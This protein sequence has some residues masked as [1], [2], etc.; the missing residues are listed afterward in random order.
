M[1]LLNSLK[2][3]K[4]SLIA[5]VAASLITTLVVVGAAGAVVAYKRA[6][7]LNFLANGSRGVGTQE[8]Q[9]E[10]DDAKKVVNDLLNKIS[11]G[12][13]PAAELSMVD[14]VKKSK[15]AVVSIV[16]S[17]DVPVYEQYYEKQSNPFKDIFGQDVPFDFNVP[18]LRQKGT[19][20]KDIG[21]GTGF[22]ISSD[23]LIVTNRHVVADTAASY[24]VITNDGKKYPAEVIA[25]DSVLDVAVV[26]IK[27]A[28]Y[29]YLE[30]GNSDKLEVGQTVLA[31]GNALGEF[32][33][34]VSVGIVSGLARSVVAGGNNGSLE[35]LDQVIQTDA[36]INPGNSGGPLLDTYGRVVGMNAAVAGGG[37]SIG[38]ALPANSIKNVVESVKKTGKIVRPFLG[39]RYVPITKELKD[40]NKLSVDYG[41]LVVRGDKPEE[42]AVVPASPA[43]KA[44]VV[45]ND[46]ILE[47]DGKKLDENTQLALVVRNKKVGD[48]VKLKM[49]HKG[50]TKEIEVKLEALPE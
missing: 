35:R 37:Q 25:R 11:D 30:F 41:V 10:K 28:N 4:S 3:Y 44:G 6:Q 2:Q 42:L 17:K 27:G 5:S 50:E 22:F 49:L 9:K 39:I 46:I 47:V 34:S 1:N 48:K 29:A 12:K 40:A 24:T 26:K 32:K 16:I 15:P 23:G 38:F 13:K 21:G 18:Q 7:V 45:E 19:E 14:I 43:D 31:I 33:N 20:K 36:A 8:D